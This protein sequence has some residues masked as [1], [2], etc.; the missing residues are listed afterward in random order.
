MLKKFGGNLK[1]SV[2]GYFVERFINLCKIK[3]IKISNITNKISKIILFDINASDFKNLKE[4]AKKTK[5]K[6][7][8]I[9]KRG[10]YF[11]SFKYRKRKI[12]FILFLSIIFSVGFINLLVLDIKITGNK[13]DE[14]NMV[15]ETLKKIGIKKGMF[16]GKVDVNKL[17]RELRDIYSNYAFIGVSKKGN[18]INID[19]VEKTNIDLNKIPNNLLGNIVAEKEGVISKI[20]VESGTAKYKIGSFFQK[21]DI[22]IEGKMYS[23]VI[24]EQ[25]V[26]PRGEIYADTNYTFEKTYKVRQNIKKYQDEINKSISISTKNM[27][28]NL[29][30]LK[31]DK[32]YDKIYTKEIFNFL[33]ISISINKFKEY[34]NED[35]LYT[36]EEI[37][38]IAKEE[39]NI[40]I[41]T[42][43][44]NSKEF[45]VIDQIE[46]LE[47]YEDE[48]KLKIEYVVN[49]KVGKLKENEI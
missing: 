21:G 25:L 11:L 8:I 47:Y 7:K 39:A 3:N 15:I 18:D 12:L 49:E 33:G 44:K 30:Y 22:L 17:Q 20:I 14:Y 45:N 9:K 16:K 26:P 29:D 48:I 40:Y 1:V 42:L 34:I 6:I 19:F 2:E 41:S 27:Q 23:L 28:Y 24:G 43:K 10:I 32:F 46:S 31:K 4:I 13:N 36:N 37:Y 5:C 35:V 38:N